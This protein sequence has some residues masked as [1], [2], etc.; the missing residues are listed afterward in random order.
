[1]SFDF[2]SNA[3]FWVHILST[4][5]SWAPITFHDLFLPQ[6]ADLEL[7]YSGDNSYA[8]FSSKFNILSY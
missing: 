1:M 7:Q 2:K 3:L 6:Q 4:K 5:Q 8:K